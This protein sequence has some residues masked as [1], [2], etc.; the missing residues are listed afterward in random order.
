[1]RIRLLALALAGGL[2]A[3]AC[4]S[5]APATPRAV[6]VEHAPTA[7]PAATGSAPLATTV[8]RPPAITATPTPAATVSPVADLPTTFVAKPLEKLSFRNVLSFGTFSLK[9]GELYVP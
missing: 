4:A 5:D 9:P 7:T 2:A 6:P 3:A 8:P 1:M